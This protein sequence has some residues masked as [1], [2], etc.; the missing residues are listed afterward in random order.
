M[1]TGNY[2][3]SDPIRSQEEQRMPVSREFLLFLLAGLVIIGTFLLLAWQIEVPTW[4]VILVSNIGTFFFG[5]Q[6]N[7]ASRE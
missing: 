5:F 6:I 7:K 2:N 4:L 1:D 3:M